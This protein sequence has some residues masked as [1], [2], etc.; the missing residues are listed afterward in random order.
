MFNTRQE[1]YEFGQSRGYSQEEIQEKEREYFDRGFSYRKENVIPFEP[2]KIV[3]TPMPNYTI[4]DETQ[5][6][7]QLKPN[8]EENHNKGVVHMYYD[9]KNQNK[10]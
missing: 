9:E 1:F 2:H 5:A 7:Q 6:S 10:R 3:N 4:V 8:F